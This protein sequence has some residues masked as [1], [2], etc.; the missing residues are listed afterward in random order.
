MATPQ[1]GVRA[2]LH[3]GIGELF[4]YVRTRTPDQPGRL[5]LSSS[6]FPQTPQLQASA[7]QRRWA[8]RG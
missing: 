7:L 4:A 3:I 8:L 6:V 5:T 1:L 2:S